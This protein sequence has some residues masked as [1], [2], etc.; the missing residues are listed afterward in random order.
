MSLEQRTRDYYDSGGT[1]LPKGISLPE[2]A[3]YAARSVYSFAYRGPRIFVVSGGT[4]ARAVGFI[5]EDYL[6]NIQE[7]KEVSLRSASN[8]YNPLAASYALIKGSVKSYCDMASHLDFIAETY[9]DHIADM[10]V[11]RSPIPTSALVSGLT[12]PS[13]GTSLPERRSR[14]TAAALSLRAEQREKN[15]TAIRLLETWLSEETDV[16]SQAASLRVT[17]TT[18][19]ADRL[20]SRKLFS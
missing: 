15:K 4:S 11:S 12:F 14:Q 19:N 17:I 13:G 9:I 3:E 1:A 20:H 5:T 18:L 10:F 6:P 2:E 16:D 8:F 7:I